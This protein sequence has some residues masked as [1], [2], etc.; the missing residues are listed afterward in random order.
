MIKQQHLRALPLL[1]AIAML[2]VLSGCQDKPATSK[3]AVPVVVAGA[4]P[5]LAAAAQPTA[6]ERERLLMSAIFGAR[7]V[8]EKAHAVADFPH[9][10]DPE[11]V[12]PFDITA[13]S[14]TVLPTGEAV[15][16]VN[17]ETIKDPFGSAGDTG[18]LS[19]LSVY[20]LRQEGA[21]WTVLE[22]FELVTQ[23]GLKG[24][25]RVE[26]ME[27]RKDI[28]GMAVISANKWKGCSY[29][30]LELFDLSGPGLRAVSEV[31]SLASTS[32]KGRCFDDVR[33][34][35][36][37]ITG[38]WKMAPAKAPVSPYD[39]L[40]ISYAG[41]TAFTEQDAEGKTIGPGKIDKVDEEPV[42][43]GA[44]LKR[45]SYV[46]ME[47]VLALPIGGGGDFI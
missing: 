28:K 18:K 2:P 23:M 33:E 35:D 9:P 39:D 34:G 7:Y 5:V 45:K 12:I 19:Y 8:P 30:S 44:D 43:Y 41:H 42:R 6:E 4:S 32:S 46:L 13:L 37:Q 21:K 26:W 22:R 10:E 27:L 16:A 15:L 36:W 17:V 1:A 38:T 25:G 40:I 11:K 14:H 31:L 29:E 47:G 20:I 3:P 24:V